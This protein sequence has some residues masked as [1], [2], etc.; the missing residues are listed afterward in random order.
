MTVQ[1]LDIIPPLL[2]A[3]SLGANLAQYLYAR[4]R[5]SAV[6]KQAAIRAPLAG[7]LA[8]AWPTPA[9]LAGSDWPVAFAR[10]EGLLLALRQL[11]SALIGARGA[12]LAVVLSVT[13]LILAGEAVMRLRADFTSFAA[14]RANLPERH[15][16][17]WAGRRAAEAQL[18]ELQ[19]ALADG[20]QGLRAYMA[21]L[22][23]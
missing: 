23:A 22:N 18:A 11:D 13:R 12:P 5:R 1:I 15:Y 10:T 9:P 4:S 19:R 20:C 17:R 14:G 8:A 7:V 6:D 16:Q 3:L 2:G 21:L